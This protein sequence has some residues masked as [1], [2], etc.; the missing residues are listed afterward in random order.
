VLSS[1]M[2]TIVRSEQDAR[3][4]A[5]VFLLELG[6]HFKIELSSVNC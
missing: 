5:D 1:V 2:E 3:R 4:G 6:E